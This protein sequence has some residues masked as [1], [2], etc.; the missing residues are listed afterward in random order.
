MDTI[1]FGTE[2]ET[3]ILNQWGNY[4]VNL[5]VLT[6]PCTSQHDRRNHNEKDESY[7]SA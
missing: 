4:R 7:R 5:S 2:E 1:Q 6:P 3:K